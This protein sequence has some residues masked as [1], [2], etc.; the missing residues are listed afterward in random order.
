MKNDCEDKSDEHKCTTVVIPGLWFSKKKKKMWTICP[1]I[2]IFFID[3]YD[4]DSPPR[5]IGS[6][7]VH[8]Q[9]T[10]TSIDEIDVM[11][12]KIR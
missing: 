5:I 11:N 4:K 3:D 6:V 1:K 10:V 8:F 12:Q 9:L 2:F 7:P